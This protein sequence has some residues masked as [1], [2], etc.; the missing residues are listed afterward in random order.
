MI[1]KI[2]I[3]G[4]VII[5][6]MF[7]VSLFAQLIGGSDSLKYYGNYGVEFSDDDD[8]I[9]KQKVLVI[10]QKGFRTFSYEGKVAE[11]RN[12]FGGKLP[13]LKPLKSELAEF[14]SFKL[15]LISIEIAAED[16]GEYLYNKNIGDP[17][18]LSKG[19]SYFG[20]DSIF[21]RCEMFEMFLNDNLAQADLVD[22]SN[23]FF[24]DVE[25]SLNL[26]VIMNK[27]VIQK[28]F[29]GENFKALGSFTLK[30]KDVY[31]SLVH[32]ERFDISSNTYKSNFANLRLGQLNC[33]EDL[34]LYSSR[35]FLIYDLFQ[36]LTYEISHSSSISKAIKER[37][38]LINQVDKL[39]EIV[40]KSSDSSASSLSDLMAAVVTISTDYGHGSGCVI[41]EDGY[42][43]TNHHVAGLDSKKL[44]IILN[45]GTR[46][47]GKLL[48]SDV[49]SDLA[50]IKVTTDHKFDFVRPNDQSLV[51]LGDKVRVI[52]TPANL[53]LGQTLTAGIVSSSR[54]NNK[55][56]LIQTDAH[57]SPGNSG[58]A[59][60]NANGELVGIVSSKAIGVV[61]EGV[62][63]AIPVKYI[64]GRLKINFE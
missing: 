41:T 27:L 57:I 14:S 35:G 23:G 42:I 25:K 44:E 47:T 5:L 34:S 9:D 15:Q 18:W 2:S 37:I 16:H 50:L 31:G 48:R 55:L 12:S 40:L 63:F 46:F 58:G 45:D 10:C 19:Y 49:R 17:K 4:L 30:F 1:G 20:Q 29:R 61:T 7:N 54:K 60:I 36:A 32:T 53:Q 28:S 13:E 11:L 3:T 38:Y 43:V 24:I 6:T 39:E 8:R 33:D 26:E 64:K 51:S 62:G 56:E 21:S 52:G 22:S 59:L